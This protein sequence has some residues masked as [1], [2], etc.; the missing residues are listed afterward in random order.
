[1]EPRPYQEKAI[2]FIIEYAAEHPSGKLLVVLPPGGG[3]TL[4]AACVLRL[5]AADQGMRGL[6]WAHRRELVGQMRDHLI[7][8]GVPEQMLGVVMA[9]DKRV[10]PSAHIQVTSVDTLRH[11]DKPPADIVVSDEAHRDASDGRRKLRAMYPTSF[12]LGMTGTPIRSDNR[13]LETDYAALYVAAQPSDLATHGWI[14]LP[15]MYTVP[16]SELPNLHGIRK[17][18]GDFDLGQLESA[19]NTKALIGSIV[20]HWVRLADNRRTIVFPVSV[21]HSR[22]IVARFLAAGIAAEHLD[23]TETVVR[24]AGILAAFAA[25]SLRVVSSCGVLSEGIDIPEVKCVVMARATESV[26]LL[27]QQGGRCMR[28][29]GDM[30]PLILDHAGNILRHGPPHAD[31]PWS[32]GL[33]TEESAARF[34]VPQKM[35]KSCGL[36]VP[37]STRICDGCGA[38]FWVPT[39][40]LIERDVDLVEWDKIA[41]YAQERGF[42]EHWARAVFDAKMKGAANG[43]AA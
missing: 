9:G 7:R 10:N 34:R 43:R 25:G 37:I 22:A 8:C 19:S 29:H 23:G 1:M 12:H 39:L 32:F 13:S 40:D 28:P 21:K 17:V 38:E 11:R 35:C 36:I 18:A 5:L 26:G 31:R 30:V 27:I 42:G 4:I 6:T 2:R 41:A 20:D 15:K 3:K 14:A 24:R 33:S 16:P